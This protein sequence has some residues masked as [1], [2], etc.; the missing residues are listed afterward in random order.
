MSKVILIDDDPIYHRISQI[1]MREYGRAEE[2]ISSTDGKATL[3][4]LIENKEK[5]ERLPDFIFV[6]LNMPEYSGWDF[7]N[8]YKKIYHSLAKAIKVYIVSSSVDPNDVRRS[9]TYSFVNSFI[10]K[11]LKK[12][13]LQGLLA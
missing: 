2:V 6:D 1:M 12:E 8:G 7:L 9:K 5:E 10:I 11:P 3:N 4:Y 13:F